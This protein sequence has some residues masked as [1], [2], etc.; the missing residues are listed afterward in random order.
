MK[1]CSIISKML[2]NVTILQRYEKKIIQNLEKKINNLHETTRK[3]ELQTKKK[4]FRNATNATIIVKLFFV[5]TENV[6][7]STS[8]NVNF[9]NNFKKNIKNIDS[10]KITVI[11]RK[12]KTLKFEKLKSYKSLSKKKHNR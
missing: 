1:M 10:T 7:V 9:K 5:L 8:N 3:I 11:S 12:I 2:K 4:Q 6:N